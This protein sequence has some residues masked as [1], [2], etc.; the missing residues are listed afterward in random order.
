MEVNGVQS[1]LENILILIAT[2]TEWQMELYN[3]LNPVLKWV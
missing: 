3:L 1:I 2:L